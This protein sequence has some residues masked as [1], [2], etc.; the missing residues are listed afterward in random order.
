[1]SGRIL[2][3]GLLLLLSIHPTTAGPLPS[4]P[5][6][7]ARAV[8][9]AERPVIDG[10]LDDPAWRAAPVQTGF[11]RLGLLSER[12]VIPDEAQTLF[13]VLYDDAGIYLGIEC[14]EPHLDQLTVRAADRHDAAMWSDDD[15]ELFIDPVGDRSEY[16]QFAVNSAGTQVDLYFIEHGHTQKPYSAVWQ[17]ATYRGA[18]RL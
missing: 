15:V 7:H 18:R 11:E 10:R 1:M 4:G 14:R 8:R 17:A 12:Q 16:Y 5:R 6:R 13:R 9:T 2:V 3:A